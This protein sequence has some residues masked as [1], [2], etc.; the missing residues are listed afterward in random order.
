MKRGVRKL[1]TIDVNT[2]TPSP[3]TAKLFKLPR[4]IRDRVYRLLWNG[5]PRIRQQ[6]KRESY[7]VNYGD[8]DDYD[9]A[10][11]PTLKVSPARAISS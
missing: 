9:T 10:N 3:S 7:C 8:L 2:I 1:S 11:L 6:Y 4:E 5:T